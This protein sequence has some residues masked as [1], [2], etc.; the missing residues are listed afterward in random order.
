MLERGGSIINVSSVIGM[1]GYYPDF[2][3][4]GLHY[5]ASKAGVVGLTRQ[6]AAEYAAQ[7]IRANVI[8][9]E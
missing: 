5:A 9:P 7:K 3:S 1:G 6:L 4:T 2:S 8:A